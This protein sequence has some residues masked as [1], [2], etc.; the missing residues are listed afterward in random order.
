MTLRGRVVK[1]FKKRY[2]DNPCRGFN[3]FTVRNVKNPKE[4]KYYNSE[5]LLI[6][7]KRQQ[8][9]SILETKLNKI[10]IKKWNTI[11]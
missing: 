5:D 9:K 1:G 8:Q 3:K 10:N 6:L 7:V 4:K 2:T 11:K